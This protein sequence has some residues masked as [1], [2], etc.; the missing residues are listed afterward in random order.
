MS[1]AGFELAEFLFTEAELSQ[2][3]IDKLLELWVATLLPHGSSPPITT[4]QH[5]HQQ[6]DAIELG[7]VHWENASLGYE[8]PLP[9][10]TRLP[11]W[12]TTKYDVWY[13]DPC[14]VVKNILSNT[15]FNGHVDYAAYQE[16][17]GE[18]R[19]YGNMMSGNWSWRQSVCILDFVSHLLLLTMLLG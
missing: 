2:K 1:R 8:G 3:K 11:E 6:I 19:Q 16:F 18:K 17:N 14:E 13:R 9:E 4:H 7:N 10:M 15:D 12:M 5:L